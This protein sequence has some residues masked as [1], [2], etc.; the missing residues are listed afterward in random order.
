MRDDEREPVVAIPPVVGLVIVRV[1]PRIVVVPVRTEKFRIA[2]GIARNAVRATAF[3]IL[4]RLYRIRHLKCPGIP[5]QV[6]SFFEVACTTLS[7]AVTADILD[8]WTLGSVAKNRDRSHIHLLPLSFY[9]EKKNLAQK[10]TRLRLNTAG[11]VAKKFSL[12]G[13]R[14][15]DPKDPK[16][17]VSRAN[18]RDDEREPAVATPPAAGPDKVR[19]EPRN[20]AV[21]ARTEK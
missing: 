3:R 8:A 6:S 19:A 12:Q 15:K 11:S 2:I 7:E 9:H 21:P 10:C 18:L 16:T 20:A 5:H 4:L 1:E 17:K 13:Q 14:S